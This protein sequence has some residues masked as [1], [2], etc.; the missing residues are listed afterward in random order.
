MAAAPNPAPALPALHVQAQSLHDFQVA[1]VGQT[2]YGAVDATTGTIYLVASPNPAD[3][4]MATKP[5]KFQNIP[6]RGLHGSHPGDHDIVGQGHLNA[7]VMSNHFF[8]IT[9]AKRGHAYGF[10]IAKTG[11]LTFTFT[12]NSGLNGFRH[13]EGGDRALSA[14]EAAHI[15]QALQGALNAMPQPIGCVI[16]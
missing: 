9:V 6:Q 3:N 1:K 16:Q 2:F 11:A 15:R 8:D 12:G 4:V 7:M 14:A 5:E 13:P 10:G